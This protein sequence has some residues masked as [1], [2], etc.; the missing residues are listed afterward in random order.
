MSR[1]N[2]ELVAKAGEAFNQHDVEGLIN[3]S[4]EELEFV[5]V[6]SAVETGEATYRGKQLW[7]RY[8]EVMD[9]IWADWQVE[10]LE[11]LDAGDDRV[12][13]IFRLV[14]TGRQSGVRAGQ[15]IGLAYRM[16][17]GKLWRMRSYVDPA[18]ALEAVGLSE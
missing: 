15:T 13:A 14:G 2:V 18:D 1:E 3:L 4:H 9:Q 7:E 8:F 17:E 16:R 6:L 10:D 5:S 11:I 12:A